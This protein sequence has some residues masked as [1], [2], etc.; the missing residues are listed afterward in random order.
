[1]D[2]IDRIA[3]NTKW[4]GSTILAGNGS[5]ETALELANSKDIQLGADASQ[6]MNLSFKSWRTKVAVDS[7]MTAADGTGRD[8]IDPVDKFIVDFTN[9]TVTAGQT[10]IIAGLT[11]T[12]QTPPQG[13]T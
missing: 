2:E 10:L 3:A 12:A 6:T 13:L 11:I 9:A 7:N 5:L 1:M 8:G 4:N